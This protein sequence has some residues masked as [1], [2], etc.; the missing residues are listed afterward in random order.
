[1]KK[2]LFKLEIKKN[3]DGIFWDSPQVSMKA[4]CDALFQIV[5]RKGQSKYHNHKDWKFKVR[6]KNAVKNYADGCDTL[7]SDVF[8]CD[9]LELTRQISFSKKR[10]LFFHIRLLVNNKGSHTLKLMR[11]IPILIQGAE[12]LTIG[13]CEAKKWSLFRQARHKNDLPSICILGKTDGAYIDALK[14]LSE[15]GEKIVDVVGEIPRT[16]VS[17][18]LTVL[19]GKEGRGPGSLLLGFLTGMS[20]L[21]K[22]EI[23][24]DRSRKRFEK[25]EASCLMDGILLEPGEQ[26]AGE[27]LRID[28]N[29]DAFYAIEK[30]TRIKGIISNSFP[31]PNPPSVYCTWYYYGGTITQED[32]I[33][34][35]NALVQYKIPIDVFQIDAGW[36]RKWGDWKANH[37]FSFGMK[38]LADRIKSCGFRPG[39]WTCPFIIDPEYKIRYSHPDWLL[40]KADGRP[41]MFKMGDMNYVLD[42]TH[43]KVLKWIENLYRKLTFE[44]GYT[45]HKLDF[46]RA[47][48]IDPEAVF[49]DRKATRTQA[50]RRGIKAVRRGAG[51]ESYISVCGG[52]Y[53]APSGLVD[54]H[55]TSSDVCSIWPVSE[56]NKEIV[57]P[58]TIKQNVL[59]YWMNNLWHNDPDALMVRRRTSMFRGRRS[60]LGLLTDNEAKIFALNQYFSGGIICFTE[61]VQQ[62]DPDRLG[63]LRHIIPS[64]GKSA[65]PRD[66]FLGERYPTIY[67]VQVNPAVPGLGE[68]HTVAFV[69]WSNKPVKF[70]FNLNENIVGEFSKVYQQY[71]ISEFWSG[72]IRD[73]I[74]YGDRIEFRELKGHSAMLVKIA[75]QTDHKPVLLYSNGHFSM[76][77]TEITSW[78]YGENKLKV[79]IDWPWDYPAEFIIQAPKNTQWCVNHI[80][81]KT[82]PSGKRVRI[83]LQGRYNEV[84]ELKLNAQG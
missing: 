70:T 69:N 20:Q 83:H 45:Y 19:K 21:V 2:S 11:L 16:V 72:D 3:I 40:R 39:I 63:L 24:I 46:T 47:V 17:D 32:I 33:E 1:M 51:S 76:G 81:C 14:G 9:G 54:A 50:F 8:A 31:L 25:L 35:L 57:A 12:N 82:T 49:H 26:R 41:V 67:D 10:Q 42:T 44:W 38:Y 29:E 48:A 78:K 23:T 62:I 4:S 13:E 75:P 22:Y 56:D 58:H 30:F 80:L 64:L 5:G 74:G 79:G 6:E 53:S 65:I 55:R 18:E 52:L 36:S 34:N 84:I 59:R 77:G 60:S 7:I 27:W 37:K 73:C 28:G 66:I 68:W 71:F 61:R 43:P 15:S